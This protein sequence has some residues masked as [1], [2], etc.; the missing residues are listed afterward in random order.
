MRRVVFRIQRFES[1]TNN[2]LRMTRRHGGD[3]SKTTVSWS[4][5][6]QPPLYFTINGRSLR[7][8]AAQLCF[9]VVVGSRFGCSRPQAYSTILVVARGVPRQH[10]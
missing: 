1:W 5:Q 7:F 4:I 2:V 3:F 10:P 9:V 6:A 8:L